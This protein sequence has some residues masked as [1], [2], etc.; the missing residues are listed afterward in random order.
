[1]EAEMTVTREDVVVSG[2]TRTEENQDKVNV[3]KAFLDIVAE[4]DV[5]TMFLS[6]FNTAKEIGYNLTDEPE[7]LLQRLS[8]E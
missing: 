1:M 6:M 7:A 3:M 8:G 2:R 4:E 5:D